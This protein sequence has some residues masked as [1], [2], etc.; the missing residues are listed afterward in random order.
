MIPKLFSAAS[1]FCRIAKLQAAASHGKKTHICDVLRDFTESNTS[2]CVFFT[3][4]KLH[5]WYQIAQRIT[6]CLFF[7]KF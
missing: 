3:I 5:K 7:M 4:F 2:P 6:L 1:A